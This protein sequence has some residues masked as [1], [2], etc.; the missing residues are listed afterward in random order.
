[1]KKLIFLLAIFLIFLNVSAQGDRL[2]DSNGHLIY[3]YNR[4]VSYV[5][6]GVCKV[7]IVFLNSA[8]QMGVSFRQEVFDSRLQWL[9]ISTGDTS[10]LSNIKVITANLAPGESV[11]WTFNYYNKKIRK[12]KLVDLEKSC[13]MLLNK[14]LEVT[15]KILPATTV[16]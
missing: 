12:D 11:S 13:I 5:A 6:S 10:N 15:K 16:K 7:N 8:Q 14:D 1:M 2:L 9:E 4:T 3:Q